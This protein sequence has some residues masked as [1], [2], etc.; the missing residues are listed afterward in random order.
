[1]IQEFLEG[2]EYVVDTVSRNGVHKVVTIWEYD[3]RQC[4]GADFIYFGLRLKSATD[5]RCRDLI[6][7]QKKVLDALEI[8]HGAGHGEV[9][10]TPDGPCLVEVGARPHGGEGSWVPMVNKCLGTSQVKALVDTFL[11]PEIFDATPDEPILSEWFG[12]EVDFVARKSGILVALPKLDDCK[13][14][15]SF[16]EMDIFVKPGEKLNMT[17]DCITTPGNVRLVARDRF[18]MEADILRLRDLEQDG[19]FVLKEDVEEKK[20]K[21]PEE[22]KGRL[23]GVTG[24]AGKPEESPKSDDP[25]ADVAERSKLLGEQA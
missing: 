7:Y 21:E 16:F 3:K 17:I 20:E 25:P 8:R 6:D 2:K 10:L 14:L 24:V 1:M 5:P 4:N 15:K 12:C 18:E 23:N 9:M 11:D 13:K 19:F 22:E